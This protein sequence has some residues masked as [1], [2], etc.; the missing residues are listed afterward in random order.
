MAYILREQSERGSR[1]TV[2]PTKRAAL[3]ALSLKN[4]DK[5]L[6]LREPAGTVWSYSVKR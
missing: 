6:K 4:V 3:Q 2:Y 5:V 1:D